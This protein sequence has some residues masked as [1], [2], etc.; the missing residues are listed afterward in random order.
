M[1]GEGTARRSARGC[2][3]P[4]WQ[5]RAPRH[6]LEVRLASRSRTLV[7]H[8]HHLYIHGGR[9]VA[10]LPH[11]DGATRMAPVP[12][13]PGEWMEA[14]KQFMGFLMMATLLWLLYILGS[15]WGWKR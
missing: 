9:D 14:A 15:S 4:S 8:H 12:S 6:S 13:K 10:S 5:R 2:L 1:K 11:P 7:G 3:P